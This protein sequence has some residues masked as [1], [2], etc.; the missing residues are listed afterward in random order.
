MDS[1]DPRV[2]SNYISSISESPSDELIIIKNLINRRGAKR[3]SS[4]KLMN[5]VYSKLSSLSLEEKYSYAET[6]KE[7][8]SELKELNDI[9]SEK[10]VLC[11][12]YDFKRQEV[13]DKKN[14]D[15]HVSLGVLINT[16]ENS[17]SQ[18][19]N[20]S[21]LIPSG[22]SQNV[23]FSPI[24]LPTFDSQPENLDQFLFAFESIMST[25]SFSPFEKYR[26]LVKQVS[27][28]AKSYIESLKVE[29]QDYD[30]AKNLLIKAYS[31]KIGQQFSVI[32]KITKLKLQ[33]VTNMMTWVSE[34]R[35]LKD[36]MARLSIDSNI[37]M[38]YFVWQGISEKIKN[39]F[40]TVN[41][42]A[43][44]DLNA[45]VDSSFEVLNRLKECTKQ[46]KNSVPIK[47]HVAETH[48]K[49][50][51]SLAA[52]VDLGNKNVSGRPSK[53]IL[54]QHLKYNGYD[55]HYISQCP[56]FNTPES[57][58]KKII[59]IGGC[60][61]CSLLNHDKSQCKFKFKKPCY[62]CNAQ[63][64]ASF[65][66]NKTKNVGTNVKNKKSSNTSQN[67][68]TSNVVGLG[69]ASCSNDEPNHPNV[70]EVH[71]L[72]T[73]IMQ[74]YILPTFTAKTHLAE[75]EIE[76]SR[77]L[78]DSA[79][80]YCFVSLS[81]AKKLNYKI[82]NHD[83]DINIKGFN[84]A[85]NYKTNII[86]FKISFGERDATIVAAV[87][88]EIKPKIRLKHSNAIIESFGKANIELADKFLNDGVGNIDIILGINAMHII[89]VHA[90]T[91]GTRTEKFLFYYTCAGVMLT[92]NESIILNNLNN[93]DV[94][95]R[96]VDKTNEFC[97]GIPKLIKKIH[98][99]NNN[100]NHNNHNAENAKNL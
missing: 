29:D 92:G 22:N 15:Y 71:S 70:L 79:S 51:V 42:D 17:L 13:I 46:D 40:M 47:N 25:R 88:P 86:E 9:I 99:N 1:Y 14:S 19:S 72:N 89:P 7:F 21:S 52:A 64:H 5:N 41:N 56:K 11:P 3:S 83:I 32:E 50:T 78:Y 97:K 76:Y 43:K 26:Y 20:Q 35:V 73:S 77:V 12:E 98:L 18:N 44:P 6:L 80:E 38:Q 30:V 4:T 63:N 59:E 27:G 8:K 34:V 28:P 54:C 75:G 16:L 90:G 84:E 58:I 69:E 62:K 91:L 37:F 24:D 36:Q 68:T 81:L 53:C 66:C 48:D 23:K 74:K 61:L 87:I 45:I 67:E 82:I 33:N 96:F 2:E 94:I 39:S 65:L 93:V 95:K 10:F 60:I 49:K 57:R 85:K 55:S 31:S 100:N